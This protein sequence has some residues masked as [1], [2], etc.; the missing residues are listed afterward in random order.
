MEF[1]D[2]KKEGDM[3][4]GF[5]ERDNPAFNIGL[6]AFRASVLG[7]LFLGGVVALEQMV[8]QKGNKVAG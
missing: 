4:H 1:F 7:W 5:R 3:Q 2:E 6:A 8:R